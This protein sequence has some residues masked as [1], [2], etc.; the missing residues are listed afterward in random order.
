M[1]SLAPD[2]CIRLDLTEL[3]G[4]SVTG[5]PERVAFSSYDGTATE[6]EGEGGTFDVPAPPSAPW[7]YAVSWEIGG[8]EVGAA[9]QVIAYHPVTVSG[10]KA[11]RPDMYQLS[12]SSDDELFEGRA[13]AV[14]QFERAAK[15]CF[16]PVMETVA[17]RVSCEQPQPLPVCDVLRVLAATCEGEPVGFELTSDC[18][19]CVDAEPGA[20]VLA[21]LVHGKAICP[22]EVSDAVTALAAWNLTPSQVPDNVLSESTDAGTLRYAVSGRDGATALPEVNAVIDRWGRK[23]LGVV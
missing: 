18:R 16:V 5:A 13:R 1:P 14:E 15:R 12:S 8:V 19:A 9:V 3:S 20:L 21:T 17:V 11:Y 2:T 23:R 4:V 7:E 6:V 22:T 10:L